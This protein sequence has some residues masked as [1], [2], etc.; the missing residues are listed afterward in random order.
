MFH[1]LPG[2]NSVGT[3]TANFRGEEL[4]A[5]VYEVPG[6]SPG[7]RNIVFEH[8]L[9]SPQGPGIIYCGDEPDRPYASDANKFAFFAAL[10]ANWV[11]QCETP[12]QVVHLHD[13]HAA[14]YLVLRQ[15]D[16]ALRPLR[17]I[18]TVFTVHNL[19]YQGARPICDDESS[20]EAWFPAL[21][22]TYSAV[23][24]PRFAECYNPM[25]AAIRLADRIS[26][27]SPTY[28]EEICHW[29]S[30]VQKGSNRN[31]WPRAIAAGSSAS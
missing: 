26:T 22:L 27:V 19:S 3:V 25:A 5:A 24:D 2:A 6:S 10:A 28:A 17:A 11:L 18:R 15:F 23:R 13:W 1:Q 14:T 30:S 29:G 31:W 7:V 21:R 12:P 4:S 9:F 20:L 8:A 16:E